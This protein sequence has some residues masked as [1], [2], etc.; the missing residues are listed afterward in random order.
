MGVVGGEL[1][2]LGISASKNLGL[3]QI[4]VR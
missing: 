3:D 4:R 1:M 2:A